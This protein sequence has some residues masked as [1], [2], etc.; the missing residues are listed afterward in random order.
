MCLGS[1]THQASDCDDF[2]VDVAQRPA[3]LSNDPLL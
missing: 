3:A 1:L 2:N